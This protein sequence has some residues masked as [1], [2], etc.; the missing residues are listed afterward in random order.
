MFSGK[1]RYRVRFVWVL[2]FAV[3]ILP[4][5]SHASSRVEDNVLEAADRAVQD[6]F[7]SSVDAD[8]DTVVVGTPFDDDNGLESG[9]VYVFV[10]SGGSW[11][12]QAKLI[13]SDGAENDHFGFSVS[14][15]GDT[16]VIG[17]E[18]DDGGRGSAYVFVR[19]GMTW[20]EQAKLTASDGAT[21]DKFGVGV[22]VQEDR[23]VV[24]AKFDDDN[25][26]DSGSVY[27]FDRSGTTWSQSQKLTV[28]DSVIAHQF[29][30]KVAIDGDRFVAS[31]I[32]DANN[33]GSVYV[34]VYSGGSWS[35]EAKLT[36][37][38]ASALDEFGFSVSIDGDSLA[39]GSHYDNNE[40]SV[41]VFDRSGGSW[42][43]QARLFSVS[44][45]GEDR[46][47]QSVDIEGDRLVV[48]EML[49][50]DNGT[51]SGSAYVF[52]RSEG[53]WSEEYR[54]FMNDGGEN[55]RFGEWV[56]LSSD[57]VVIGSKTHEESRGSA[58]VFDLPALVSASTSS[59]QIRSDYDTQ[60][61]V[62]GVFKV[63]SLQDL[64]TY[65]ST[66][67][68]RDGGANYKHLRIMSNLSREVLDIESP[69][70]I[71][72]ANGVDLVGDFV[73]LDGRKGVAD[74]NHYTI[75]ATEACILSEEGDAFVG[76][77][78]TVTADDLTIDAGDITKLAHNVT[79]TVTNNFTWDAPSQSK[80]RL[81]N[82]ATVNFGSKSGMCAP[83][84]P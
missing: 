69:G 26:I 64:D 29:G 55:D 46:F 70:V 38:D 3:L 79:V 49:D 44:G 83:V 17:A 78:S 50:D 45:T 13:A 7:A 34:F 20:S 54:L 42:V 60:A 73:S 84:L 61:G 62:S 37:S 82:S 30:E 57:R 10:H 81:K 23:A 25:Q 66:D 6:F 40:G 74:S 24:G 80:C 8:G 19:S 56:T 36:A 41:Y 35:Q 33:A 59:C 22:A 15:D 16:V 72:V 47:G 18:G 5:I 65:V 14:I 32:G 63:F 71:T 21:N 2:F 52:V 4:L 31:A 11:S 48:G 67:F 76:N 68:G 39:V 9:S 43:Q 77:G 51:N 28:P 53:T 75:D 1:H 12:Q 58:Y 27:V